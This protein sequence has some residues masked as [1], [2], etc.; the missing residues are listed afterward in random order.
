MHTR[1]DW[2]DGRWPVSPLLLYL[3]NGVTTIRDFGPN[4][5]N[6]SYVLKWHDEI[7]SGNMIGPSL[8]TS[9]IQVRY[10]KGINLSPQEIVQSNYMQGYDFLKV[11]SYVSYAG[12]QE[13]MATARQL[14]MYTAGH[15]PYPV[16]L[17]HVIAEGLNEIAHIEELDWEFL[18]INRDTVLAWQNWLPYLIGSVLKQNNVVA[19]FNLGDFQVRYGERLGE[20]ISILKSNRIPLCT[21][22]MIDKIMEEK[23][24]E[25][26]T[27][28]SRSEIRYLP[29]DYLDAFNRGEE[30]HQL[31]LQGIENLAKFKYE[32]D[33][34]LLHELFQAGLVLLLSTDSGTGTMGIVPGF[35]IHDELR[36]LT[37]NG[38]SP[39]EAIATGTI[40]AAKIAEA[41][42][43]ENIFG[44]IETGKRADLILVNGNPLEN[45]ANIKNIVGVMA[46]GRWY[47]NQTLKNMISF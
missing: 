41:M 23:L 10:D 11:Y 6:L 2:L 38:L 22:M 26:G 46:A 21:T 44:T 27:F 34:M 31:Q 33:K 19:G 9:G 37:E 42:T 5:T 20:V 30:K 28:L 17:D 15:I 36:I 24:F 47:S 45:V 32:T 29:Q 4:G 25:P 35:S 13:A 18:E 1:E 16:G 12:F 7:N 43:G 3:A 8:Y 14:G 39:Y 40:N